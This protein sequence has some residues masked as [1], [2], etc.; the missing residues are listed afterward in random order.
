MTKEQERILKNKINAAAQKH[1]PESARR[2]LKHRP[3]HRGG[4]AGEHGNSGNDRDDGCERGGQG[5]EE[6][7]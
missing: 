7:A 1:I 6:R 3:Y 5:T 4:D 2:H